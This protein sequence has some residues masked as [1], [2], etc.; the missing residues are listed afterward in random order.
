MQRIS[1][2]QEQRATSLLMCWRCGAM[3][4]RR[5]QMRT[6]TLESII[7][8]C[9][10]HRKQIIWFMSLL[11]CF[12]SHVAINYSHKV[13]TAC[14]QQPC[15][16]LKGFPRFPA[17]SA[18][19]ATAFI[20]WHWWYTVIW[21]VFIIQACSG[22][23]GFWCYSQARHKWCCTFMRQLERNG[24]EPLQGRLG[25][26]LTRRHKGRRS[27]K[28]NADLVSFDTDQGSKKK[29]MW[30]DFLPTCSLPFVLGS[31]QNLIVSTSLLLLILYL[32]LHDYIMWLMLDHTTM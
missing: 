31:L 13:L 24:A 2:Q 15:G 1:L 14:H 11:P 18:R 12:T 7:L 9:Q 30:P 21:W 4:R 23:K 29:N 28:V 22:P 10:P 32:S 8:S 25:L 3:Q 16:T 20:W 19:L 6:T 27:N 26:L 5:N 17:S